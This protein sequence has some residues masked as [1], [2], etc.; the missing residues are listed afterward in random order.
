MR[1]FLFVLAA[2]IFACG[3]YAQDLHKDNI[4]IDVPTAETL[5]HYSTMLNT[6]FYTENSVMASVDF[7]IYPRL[8]IGFSIAAQNLLGNETPIKVLTPD[9]QVKYKIYDGSL[10]LPAIAIGYDGRRYLYDRDEDDYKHDRK[11][12]YLV[13]SR[14]VFIPN[15]QLHAGVNV[16]DFDSSDVFG[17]GSAN[18][19]IEDKVNLMF[20][21]DN[22]HTIDDSRLNAG[23]RI[24]L[25]DSVDLDLIARDMTHKSTFE[26]V[27]Q[28]RYKANF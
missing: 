11:G 13:L 5:D 23:I 3:A 6:R 18:F 1:K 8:N 16:S 4:L 25:S 2:F 24:Y 27:L 15:L 28:V 7:G 22:V 14:E 17:F 9:F 19:N 20:E 21:W 26:R 12:A 10:Y